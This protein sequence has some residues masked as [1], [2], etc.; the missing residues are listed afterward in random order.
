ML[1]PTR[2]ITLSSIFARQKP[3]PTPSPSVVANI[4]TIEADANANPHD[5]QKQI[6][7]FDALVNTGVKP[8]YDVV[9]ARWERMCE[10]VSAQIHSFAVNISYGDPQDATN[11][12]LKSDPAFQLYLTALMKNGLESSVNSA[13]RRRDS[14]LA[15]S[16]PASQIPSTSSESTSTA[17]A[18]ASGLSTTS[19]QQPSTSSQRIAQALLS[20]NPPNPSSLNTDIAKLAAALNTGV[21]I[22]GNPI[23]VT[24]TERE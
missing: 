5:V 20:G 15:L 11:S 2:L 7:L 23:A 14:L 13:V 1:T 16:T 17:E 8:G 10:F 19:T 18:T 12:L 22:P 6:A 24:I 4:A 9:I 3:T 21:G